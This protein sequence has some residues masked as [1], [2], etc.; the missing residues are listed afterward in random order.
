MAAPMTG[1]SS[2]PESVVR[3]GEAGGPGFPAAG[4]KTPEAVA[5]QIRQVR[6]GL[7]GRTS[8]ITGPGP[9]AGGCCPRNPSGPNRESGRPV[10]DG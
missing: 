3:V 4:Y 9:S 6:A 1:G 10:R 8:P 5:E 7:R 2:T